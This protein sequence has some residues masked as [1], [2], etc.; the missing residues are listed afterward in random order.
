MVARHDEKTSARMQSE[1]VVWRRHRRQT[2][3]YRGGVP[4]G[5]LVVQ[6]KKR[7]NVKNVVFNHLNLWLP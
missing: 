2:T 6:T 3:R 5:C 1:D 4:L 7:K